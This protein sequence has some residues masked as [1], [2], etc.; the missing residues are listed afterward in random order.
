M[1]KNN[2]NTTNTPY[3][4]GVTGGFGTGKSL[5]GN[6]LEELG[7]VVID[8]DEIVRNILKTKNQVTQKIQNE[9]D[10]SIISNKTDE[11]I[12]RK[13]LAHLIF[14]DDLKRKKLESIVHPEVDRVLNC[15]IL[16]NKSE[17][18]TAVVVLIPLLFECGLE[19]FYN[20]I[21]CITCNSTTQSERLLKKGFTPE[22]IKL[23]I[24]SQLPIDIKAK[25]S[26]FIID[27][28]GTI[29]ETKQQVI[30]R[31]KELVQLNRKLHLS[32]DK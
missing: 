29:N 17:D 13:A 15:F 19:N 22:E 28:S 27:N 3:L 10:G 24:D 23:R 31:L 20:E 18:V 8:T 21:W 1:E 26:N 2:K 16:Q 14:N 32:F 12:N 25:K 4:I 7:L 5:V 6:I 30:S 9:F 11:Y